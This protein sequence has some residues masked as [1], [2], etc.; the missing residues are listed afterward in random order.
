MVSTATVMPASSTA[1]MSTA[2]TST[3]AATSSSVMP[4]ATAV[5]SAAASPEPGAV[6]HEHQSTWRHGEQSSIVRGRYPAGNDAEAARRAGVPEVLHDSFRDTFRPAPGQGKRFT[7]LFFA[8]GSPS[9][10]P[11]VASVRTYTV[12]LDAGS[13]AAFSSPRSGVHGGPPCTDT[14]SRSIGSDP[15]GR[16]VPNGTLGTLSSSL[17]GQAPSHETAPCCC[18][19][20]L[21]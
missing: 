9:G 11:D 2:P 6:E 3:V 13:G 12:V 14:G 18:A 8:S 1:T 20:A 7:G 15:D 17:P 16:A 4:A 21:A 5:A 10:E 19:L